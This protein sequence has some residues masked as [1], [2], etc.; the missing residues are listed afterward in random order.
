[1]N[2]RKHTKGGNL[3]SAIE[4]QQKVAKQ[5]IGVLKLKNTIDWELFRPVLE[6]VT[7]Y[8]VKDWS[9]GGNLPFDPM[10]M[11]KIVII[12]F[13]YGLSDEATEVQIADRIS[14]QSFLNLQMGDDIPDRNT[15]WDFKELI[16]KDGRNGSN[17]LFAAFKQQLDQQGFL[18]KEG[19]IIDASFI[20]APKQRNSREQNEQIKKGERPEGFEK[21]T[22]KGSQKDCDARWTKKNNETHYG[23]KNHTKVDAKTK[24]IDSYETTPANVHDSQVFETLLDKK[25]K[26]IVADSAYKSEA[27]EEI[28]LKHDLEEFIMHKGYRGNP[29]S[30]S[31]K[32]SNKKLSRIRVRVEHVFGRMRHMGTDIFRRI[33]LTRAKQHNAFSNLTYNMDRYAFLTR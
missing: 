11:F 10:L 14:F 16:E 13:Y 25:D 17:K 23:Y 20:E 1:M 22:A 27:N 29:L 15:I 4:H 33:G 19:S 7:G 9:K 6:Q 26:A 30:E 21:D 24:L 32:E 18:A 5:E 3:F 31:D 2:Y 8:D 12:Q 28:L